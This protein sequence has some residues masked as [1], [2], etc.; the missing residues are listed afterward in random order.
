MPPPRRN[1]SPIYKMCLKALEPFRSNLY[2]ILGDGKTIR[3][4]D[5]SIM[6]D[7]PL[8]SCREVEQ[9]RNWLL[10]KGIT[11]LSDLSQW[12]DNIWIGWDLGNPPPELAAESDLLSV[13]LQGKSPVKEEIETKEDGEVTQEFIPLL[14]DT[15]SFRLP[16][17]LLPILQSGNSCGIIAS[18][19]KLICSAGPWLTTVS[20]LEKISRNEGWKAP[21][22]AHCAKWRLKQRITSSV[23]VISLKNSGPR[24]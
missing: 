1:G 21:L 5:D 16:Q 8:G 18:F 7:T 13:L 12:E 14:K 15:R 23:I 11:L 6:G 9:L 22:D 3:V 4:W 24:P 10:N 2:W 20:L 19:Q 17:A